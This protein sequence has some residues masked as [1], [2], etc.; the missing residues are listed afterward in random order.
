MLS[1]QSQLGELTVWESPTLSVLPEGWFECS[2]AGAYLELLQVCEGF[3]AVRVSWDPFLFERHSFPLQGH[4]DA[5]I[6][7]IA[8]F[9][10]FCS[11]LIGTERE[12]TDRSFLRAIVNNT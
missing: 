10:H 9:F 1:V 4:L 3:W 8:A 11:N 2:L 12:A 7:N 5:R 6:L